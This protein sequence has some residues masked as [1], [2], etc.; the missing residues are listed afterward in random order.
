MTV[1]APSQPRSLLFL[2]VFLAAC[3]L[4]AGIGGAVTAVSLPAWYAHL[5]KPPFNPPNWI[6]GPVWTA[7][8]L[9]MA[10][11]AWRVSRRGGEGQ[12]LS[13]ALGL[14]TVQLALNLGWSLIFF[15]LHAPGAAAAELALLLAAIVA[16]IWAFFRIDRIAGVMMAPYLAWCSFA[17]AL[18]WAVWRLN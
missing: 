4:V 16:T 2:A 18:N 14:W 15:G 11:A 12:G 13:L 9:L 5:A 8:Y 6:F 3:A 17:F 1:A 7:L 10:I